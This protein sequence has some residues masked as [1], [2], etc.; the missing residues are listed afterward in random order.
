MLPTPMRSQG[1]G[2]GIRF[3]TVYKATDKPARSAR[4]CC[5][6]VTPPVT[7]SPVTPLT[8]LTPLVLPKFSLRPGSLGG[9][10]EEDEEEGSEEGEEGKEGEEGEGLVG[11]RIK[12]AFA[13]D[14]Y[15][16]PVGQTDNRFARS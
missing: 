7:H 1:M 6:P 14:A 11:D 5:L 9:V 15:N 2:N 13:L 12:F 3:S 10:C 8:P 4:F 16:D